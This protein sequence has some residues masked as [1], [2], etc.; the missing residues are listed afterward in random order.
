MTYMAIA[1][2][3]CYGAY[4]MVRGWNAPSN[5]KAVHLYLMQWETSDIPEG[6]LATM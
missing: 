2:G 6:E 4:D 3:S 5:Y 1:E